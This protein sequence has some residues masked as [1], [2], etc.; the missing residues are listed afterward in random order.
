MNLTI[1]NQ[2]F[3][4]DAQIKLFKMNIPGSR[5]S[6]ECTNTTI[7]LEIEECQEAFHLEWVG[8]WRSDLLF[9]K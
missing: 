5:L 3:E 9:I 4:D 8:L 7:R 6:G 2:N 1:S